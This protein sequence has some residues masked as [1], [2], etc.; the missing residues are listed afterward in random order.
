MEKVLN[1][2][3]TERDKMLSNKKLKEIELLQAGK[4]SGLSFQGA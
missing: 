1:V 2:V 4:L 3:R